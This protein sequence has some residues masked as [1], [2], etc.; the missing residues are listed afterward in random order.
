MLRM[1]K[2]QSP[3][4]MGAWVLAGFGTSSGAAATA[5]ILADRFGFGA[6][7]VLGNVAEGFSALFGL[8]FSNYTGVLI[9]ADR[10]PRVESQCSYAAIPLRY[11]GLG[12]YLLPLK[13]T[14]ASNWS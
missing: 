11:V 1:F 4:S 5:Q 10:H 6:F 2:P 13:L 3:M 9:G 8:P 14:K 12:F 7:R